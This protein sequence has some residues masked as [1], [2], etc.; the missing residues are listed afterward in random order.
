MKE[1]HDEVDYNNLIR[2]GELAR[3]TG[4][5]VATLRYFESEELIACVRTRSRYRMFP[6]ETVQVIGDIMHL[7][8]LRLPLKEIRAILRNRSQGEGQSCEEYEELQNRLAH[9]LE[10]KRVW[11]EQESQVRSMLAFYDSQQEPESEV[12]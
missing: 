2:I 11:D 6:K 1:P 12:G 9:I 10:Q 4:I 5:T 3:R 7:K 8:T